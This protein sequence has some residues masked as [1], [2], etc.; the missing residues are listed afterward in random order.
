MSAQDRIAELGLTLPAPSAGS[1]NRVGA[2]RTGDLLYTSGHGPL[3]LADGSTL[4]GKVGTDLTVE[5]GYEAARRT[6]LAL[7]ATIHAE[8]GSL[9]RVTRVV[10]VLGMVNCA[11]GMNQ[12]SRVVDGCSDLFVEVFGP[13]IG[14]HARSAVGMAELP[15]DFPV[16]IE[17][18]VEIGPA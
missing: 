11:P 18:I 1:A 3:P 2:V 8:L 15:L 9:D 6:G 14:R 4:A 12:T 10:K 7:L 13:Q 16:E 5:Q 17:V